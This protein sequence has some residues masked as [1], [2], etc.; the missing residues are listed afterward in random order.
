MTSENQHSDTAPEPVSTVVPKFAT[1]NP[2][3]PVAKPALRSAED[4]YAQHEEIG[5]GG[6]GC[7]YRV[8][9][10]D[11]NRNIAMKVLTQI[12]HDPESMKRFVAEAQ[13]SG[14]LEHPGLLPIHDFGLNAEGE[15]FFTMRYVPHHE[16]LHDIIHRLRDGDVKTHKQYSIERRVH[17]IQQVCEALS[18]AHARGVIHRDIKPS[19]IIIGDDGE[20][21]LADWGVACL[22]ESGAGAVSTTTVEEEVDE[23]LLIGTPLYMSPEQ[24]LGDGE[25]TPSSDVYSLCAVAYELFSLHHYLGMDMA[26]NYHSIINALVCENFTDAEDHL[27]SLNGR[28]PRQ[29]SRILRKGLQSDRETALDSAQ[30]LHRALQRWVEGNAPVVC[31]G[32][33]IQYGLGRWSRAIDRWPVLMPAISLVLAGLVLSSI[34]IAVMTLF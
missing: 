2:D 29:L 34:A 11:L 25:I 14:Q 15:A 28:V 4:R 27:Q 17:I 12:S 3:K 22:L 20:I 26:S 7:V 24:L 1:P 5:R 19:N 13:I 32:T 30:A 23:N 16:T 9:D 10:Q 21:Y 31:P 6:M 18:Y 33:M 8:K